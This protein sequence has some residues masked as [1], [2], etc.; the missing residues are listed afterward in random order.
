MG[1]S[2]ANLSPPFFLFDDATAEADFSIG[3]SVEDGGLAGGGRFYLGVKME[4]VIFE[5]GGEEFAA[6]AEADEEG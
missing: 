6:V 5:G 1:F 4:D 2:G 3:A